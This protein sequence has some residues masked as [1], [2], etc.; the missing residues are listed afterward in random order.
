MEEP[1]LDLLSRA[2]TCLCCAFNCLKVVCCR[3]PSD[4]ICPLVQ[5]AMQV[6]G[7]PDCRPSVMQCPV[8]RPPEDWRGIPNGLVVLRMN[9]ALWYSCVLH[10]TSIRT[11]MQRERGSPKPRCFLD[12]EWRGAVPGLRDVS[13]PAWMKS[14]LGASGTCHGP[15]TARRRLGCHVVTTVRRRVE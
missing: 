10:R 13:F 12:T 3:S 7:T 14:T 5:P 8:K 11:S 15:Q 1:Q 4:S 6:L 2:L 9:L